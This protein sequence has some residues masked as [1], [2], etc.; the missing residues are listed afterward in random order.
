MSRGDVARAI[1]DA[2]KIV[3]QY[4]QRD[5]FVGASAPQKLRIQR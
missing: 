5:V 3:W 1:R 2:Q 4:G